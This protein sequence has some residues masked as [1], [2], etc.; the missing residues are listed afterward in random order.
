VLLSYYMSHQGMSGSV[1]ESLTRPRSRRHFT[2][3]ALRGVGT[4]SECDC[5]L[6]AFGRALPQVLSLL[7]GMGSGEADMT[8]LGWESLNRDKDFPELRP[9]PRSGS[10][11]AEF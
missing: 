9:C 11:E 6:V 5:P 7:S 10:S 4:R 2:P 8:Y 1:G 3:A